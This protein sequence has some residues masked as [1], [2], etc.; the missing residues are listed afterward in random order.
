MTRAQ[1]SLNKMSFISIQRQINV[2]YVFVLSS[3][4]FLY[5]ARSRKLERIQLSIAAENWTL[6]N[7]QSSLIRSNAPM[8]YIRHLLNKKVLS[9]ARQLALLKNRLSQQCR[10]AMCTNGTSR[11]VWFYPTFKSCVQKICHFDIHQNY[12][13]LYTTLKKSP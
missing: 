1:R 5:G 10:G 9:V 7:T 3:V 13:R 4:A 2:P 6:S 12:Y 11:R 8:P